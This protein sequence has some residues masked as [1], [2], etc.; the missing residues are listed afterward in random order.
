[1]GRN[2]GGDQW[3]LFIDRYEYGRD[4]AVRF[5]VFVGLGNHDLESEPRDSRL[6]RDLYRDRMWD[7]VTQRHSGTN[8]PVLVEDI[9]PDSHSYSWNWGGVHLVQLHRFGGDTRH[10]LPSSIPWL[11]EN[12]KL[13]A[14]DG[15][16]VIFFQ[17][18]GFESGNSIGS[19]RRSRSKWT[20]GE[21]NQFAEVIRDYNVVGLFHGHDHWTQRPYQW[22]GYNV[23]S[24]GAAH[25]GQFAVVHIDNQTMD[26][27]Y[28]EV[29]NDAGDVR[30]VSESAFSKNVRW[31]SQL[32]GGSVSDEP[33]ADP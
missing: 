2:K 27:V 17:H 9:D 22:R 13:H 28:A 1:M 24:P 18:Y 31:K 12:L 16:P 14:G 19:Y 10:D 29:V 23:F 21:M 26:V 25:F 3:Q 33:V 7:Y 8:A 20:S 30:L 11:R 6:P 15:R 4:N 32:V 5:P